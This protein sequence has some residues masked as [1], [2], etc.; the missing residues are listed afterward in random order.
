MSKRTFIAV[1]A[2]IL[3]IVAVG[4][5]SKRLS[6]GR[7]Q[8]LATPAAPERIPIAAPGSWVAFQADMRVFLPG[9]SASVG[10]FAR[11]TNGSIFMSTGP[12]LTDQ[13]VITI[14][15]IPTATFYDFSNGRWEKSPMDVDPVNY[16]P[17]GRLFPSHGLELYPF[18]LAFMAGQNESIFSSEGIE[19]YRVVAG[20]GSVR[21]EAPSLNFFG[22]VRQNITGRRE[23]YFNIRL[24]SPPID[25]FEPPIGS[26]IKTLDGYRRIVRVPHE[27]LEKRKLDRMNHAPTR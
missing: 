3:L 9:Y 5:A 6:E 21:L 26:A 8:E 23:E 12:T 22:L 10:R 14:R 1:T 16:R 27:A 17:K 18:K 20:D 25:L 15:N 11:D 7:A 24:E 2:P 13:G 4:L 19:V